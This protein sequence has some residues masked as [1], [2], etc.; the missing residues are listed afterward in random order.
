[1][2]A[3]Q[4]TVRVC[5]GVELDPLYADVIIRYYEASTG[6]AAILAD[7]GETFEE[8]ATRGRE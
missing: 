7:N 8:V 3:A 6:I 5:C 4:N 1:L 2:I